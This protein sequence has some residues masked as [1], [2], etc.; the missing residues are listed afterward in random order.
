MGLIDGEA[1]V[2]RV[3]IDNLDLFAIEEGLAD[4][5]GIFVPFLEGFFLMDTDN[6]LNELT[7]H[8]HLHLKE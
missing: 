6:Y 5:L 7:I 2:P 1:P 4:D 8:L 3:V